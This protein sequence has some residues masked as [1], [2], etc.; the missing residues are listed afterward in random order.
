MLNR[1]KNSIGFTAWTGMI[2]GMVVC[3]LIIAT[4]MLI[5]PIFVLKG[6]IDV[7]IMPGAAIVVQSL[8]LIVSL[9]LAT[10]ASLELRW[11]HVCMLT[12]LYFL[13]VSG[14]GIL[15]FGVD[16]NKLLY[17]AA[18]GIISSAFTILILFKV[19]ECPK[20]LAKKRRG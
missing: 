11:V 14:L 16:L 20:H 1:R 8:A 19:K 9:I 12:S 7:K 15:L 13:V 2:L 10:K 18:S 6:Y 5:L 4:G 17:S 3:I